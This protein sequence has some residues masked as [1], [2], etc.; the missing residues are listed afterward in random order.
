M[1]ASWVLMA[2]IGLQFIAAFFAIRLIK[3]TGRSMAWG[4]IASAVVMMAVRRCITLSEYLLTSQARPPDLYAELVA[5]LISACM[6]LG[7]ERIAPIFQ[8][9]KAIGTKLRE[10]EGRYRALFEHAPDAII[11][12]D[13]KTGLVTDANP[14]AAQLLGRS[15]AELMGLP[16]AE[17]HPGATALDSR[18]AFARHA[19]EEERDGMVSGP[20]EHRVLRGDGA[21]LPVEIMTQRVVVNDKPMIQG[22]F[23][24][25]SKRKQ[26]E[27]GARK[28]TEVVEKIFAMTTTCLAYMDRDFN[29]IRVNT[30]Y[31]AADDR[32]VAYYIG[33]NHFDLYPNEENQAIFREVVA[34]GEPYVAQAK[35]FTYQAHPERG[36]SLWDWSLIPVTD[37]HGAV[38][39]LILSLINVT[40]RVVAQQEL[41]RLNAELEGRVQERTAELESK[42]AALKNLNNVFVGRELKMVELKARIKE[43]EERLT[44]IRS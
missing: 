5:L 42:N 22:I 40:D 1:I 37:A 18:E 34:S 35:P 16:Q 30:E 3:V 39:G 43:L 15:H 17:L 26:A 10:S 9:L 31:A 7:I 41:A 28:S 33:K 6:A 20:F 12:T 2:S 4:L 38:E 44:G 32:E 14:K 36:V 11:I 19:M 13:R 23:R 25:I 29:F 24:D 21:E 27:E 8:E